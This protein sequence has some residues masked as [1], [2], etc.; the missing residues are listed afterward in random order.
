[1]EGLE[2]FNV[3]HAWN[4][5]AFFG[6]HSDLLKINIDT[7][8]N[9]WVV[10]IVLTALLILFRIFMH[11]SSIL[12]F[13]VTSF[14]T[15]FMDLTV[16]SIGSFYYN[17]F[18]F[19]ASI[20]IFIIFCNWIALIPFVEEP[21]KDINTTLALGCISF[22][23]KEFYAIK[24][25][26]FLAYMKEFFHPFFVMFPLNLISHF[27]KIISISFRL[28]GNIFGGSIIS[29]IYI[30]AISISIFSELFGLLSGINF[31]VLSFFILFEGLIQAFV[32][33]MLTI[34]Y[35]AIA[36]QPAEEGALE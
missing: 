22:F 35:L 13:M 18:V 14:V 2:V 7:I 20:F 11:K 17:H 31:L 30:S 24:I 36:I 12:N 28:F 10:L 21:T 4:P 29:Q 6:L 27:S 9:T 8:F 15:S 25:H 23:Y 34:T 32:F 3:E 16:Q 5:F 1:M 19:V 33:T 26:G